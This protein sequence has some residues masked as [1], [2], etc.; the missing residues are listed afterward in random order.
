MFYANTYV[1]ILQ[2]F[3]VNERRTQIEIQLNIRND[4]ELQNLEFVKFVI[5][6]NFFKIRKIQTLDLRARYIDMSS[7]F[8]LI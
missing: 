4:E 7:F 8:M 6:Q 2:W 5:F 3:V 1:D